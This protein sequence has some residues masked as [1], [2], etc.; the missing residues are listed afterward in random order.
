MLGLAVLLI[1]SGVWPVQAAKISSSVL[2]D[3]TGA[4]FITGD[5]EQGD[6]ARFRREAQKYSSAMVVLESQGG[7]TIEAI[8]I[9]KDVRLKGFGTVAL[10]D[11]FC[12]SACAL[13][14]LAGSP[15]GLAKSGRVG[16]HATYTDSGGRALESGVGNAIVGRYLTLLNLPERALIFATSASPDHLNYLTIANA[17]KTGIDVEVL[18][19]FHLNDPPPLVRTTVKKPDVELWSNA[20]GWK[21]EVD[22]TLG[23]G[24]FIITTY[25]EGTV[26]RIGVSPQDGKNYV[27][28]AN[29]A[30]QSL[31]VGSEYPLQFKFGNEEPWDA[32]ATAILLQKATLLRFYFSSD[33]FW[34][35][36]GSAATLAITRGGKKVA[37]LDLEGSLAALSKLSE[38]QA[39]QNAAKRSRDPFAE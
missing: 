28:L 21:I 38:C 24:C 1:V 19:D 33:D 26:L 5:I 30:W 20:N 11:S 39:A 7:S 10:N 36:F 17:A 4:I 14:W 27:L 32:P 15:R 37:T 31:K 22:H 3:G 13:I 23:D 29:E 6:S 25:D 34:K 12:N 16:F 9:G 35:E 8:E 2:K 18:D